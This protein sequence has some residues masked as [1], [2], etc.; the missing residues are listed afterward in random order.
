MNLEVNRTKD[1]FDLVFCPTVHYSPCKNLGF[2]ENFGNL[3]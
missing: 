2:I 3:Y 1:E